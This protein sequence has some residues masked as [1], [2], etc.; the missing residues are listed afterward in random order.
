[1]AVLS[2]DAILAAKPLME[3][4]ATEWGGEV[5]VRAQS[6]KARTEMYD[7]IVANHRALE[8]YADD[9]ALPEGE[10]AGVAEVK[11]LDQAVVMLI[12]SICD[13]SGKLI[14]TMDDI[15]RFEELSYPTVM[16]LWMAAKRLNDTAQPAQ[17]VK[18]KTSR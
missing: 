4:F 9:Q 1:M 17:P 16:T 8:D 11:P 18:K 7:V 6:V 2:R 15:D 3:A 10:R 13:E 14:F 5:N 12:F